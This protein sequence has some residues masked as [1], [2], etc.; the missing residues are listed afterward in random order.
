MEFFSGKLGILTGKVGFFPE[1]DVS[2]C[3][4]GFSWVCLLAQLGFFYFFRVA[5]LPETPFF[6][7]LPMTAKRQSNRCV[8]QMC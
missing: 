4:L 7:M 8:K 3:D 5:T 6:H 2:K 1:T